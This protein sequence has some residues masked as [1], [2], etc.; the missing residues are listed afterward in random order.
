M[1]SMETPNEII[2]RV[3]ERFAEADNR[4]TKWTNLDTNMELLT[5]LDDDQLV[6]EARMSYDRLVNSGTPQC[7]YDHK[8][9]ECFVPIIMKAT[10]Y[11]MESYERIPKL[12]DKARYIAQYFISLVAIKEIFSVS[13][14]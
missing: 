8:G 5:W 2:D 10:A 1:E 6:R 11:I 14:S 3:F 9:G 4:Q 7:K 12:T 13:E